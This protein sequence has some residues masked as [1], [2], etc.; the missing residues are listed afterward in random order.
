ME[1]DL[2]AFA[3]AHSLGGQL[4]GA[5]AEGARLNAFAKVTAA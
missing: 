3:L 4:S 5:V 1:P 2:P